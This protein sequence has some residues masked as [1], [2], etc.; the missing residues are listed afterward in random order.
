MDTVTTFHFSRN[1][2]ADFWRPVSAGGGTAR[3]GGGEHAGRF[4]VYRVIR[5]I[6]A[7]RISFDFFSHNLCGSSEEGERKSNFEIFTDFVFE[8]KPGES[9]CLNIK[10]VSPG[11]CNKIQK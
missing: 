11:P 6:R 10:S 1:R 8:W 2:G 7:G 3:E 5:V 4:D 9:K